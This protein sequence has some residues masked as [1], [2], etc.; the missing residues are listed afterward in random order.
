MKR[1]KL[2]VR[3]VRAVELILLVFCLINPV[4]IFDFK[5]DLGL[6]RLQ[7][8]LLNLETTFIWA[9]DSEGNH[10]VSVV[11]KVDLVDWMRSWAILLCSMYWRRRKG[12]CN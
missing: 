7:L 11:S 2:H 4:F 10:H 8:N 3:R 12:P 5:V 6:R 9:Q 1:G